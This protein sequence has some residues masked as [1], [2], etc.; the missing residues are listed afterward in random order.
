MERYSF[1]R[2]AV[3]VVLHQ[4][5][6]VSMVMG[7][8]SMDF[9]SRNENMRYAAIYGS[10]SIGC[11][12]VSFAVLA[13][14]T[15]ESGRVSADIGEISLWTIDRLYGDIFSI[16]FVLVVAM[17]LRVITYV[18]IRDFSLAGL[19]LVSG[20]IGYLLD[21]LFL[22]YYFSIVRRIKKG[23]I[24]RQT[25]LYQLVVFI[26]KMF[27]NNA[28]ELLSV[29]DS[30]EMIR[31]IEAV[32]N[33][34]EGKLDVKLDTEEYH[35]RQLELA[36][37]IN[38]IGE[39][40]KEAIAANTK[41]ERMKA[42]LITNVSHDL[43]TPLTSIVNYVDL[44]KREE[45][46]NERAKDYIRIIDEKSQRLKQLT[47]DLVEASKISSGNIKL[48]MQ[49]IDFVEL[50]YQAG[51]EFDDRFEARGLT[52]V[53]KLP[54]ESIMIMA[55]GRQLYRVIENLYTNAA[56]YAMEN[57]R[58]YVEMET[59]ENSVIF[60]IKNISQKPMD[61]QFEDG[62]NELAERFVRGESSR[63]TEGSGLGL[64][65]ARDLTKLMGAGF[66]IKAESDTFSVRITF[67]M[68]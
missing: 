32:K 26:K 68:A 25:F 44:L 45:L 36:S 65:I 57:T 39:G 42:D 22:L 41:S 28:V 50:L 8:F 24:F 54:S 21:T 12:I 33:I 37:A 6:F 13:F 52:I 20:T 11:F 48:D 3:A 19:L 10:V 60:Q 66:E 58:V 62:G 46:Y 67:K 18:E 30:K 59:D 7:F 14:L 4:L 27:S 64:S 17:I 5:F 34:A 23:V 2:K 31:L 51:G 16:A 1:G 9:F 55:D 61:I 49:R 47:E 35:G 53:T 63:S 40:M 56:K 15:K 29:E 43:K 38:Q